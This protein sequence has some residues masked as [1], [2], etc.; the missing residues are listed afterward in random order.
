MANSMWQMLSYLLSLSGVGLAVAEDEELAVT[1]ELLS[2]KHGRYSH[3]IKCV[4]IFG[5]TTRINF[6]GI[7]GGGKLAAISYNLLFCLI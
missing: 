7:A 2:T 4:E 5:F 6:A 3:F 1:E